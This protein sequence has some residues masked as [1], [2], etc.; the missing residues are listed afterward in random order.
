MAYDEVLRNRVRA[1]LVHT[2]RV[3][4]KGMFGWFA[5]LVMKSIRGH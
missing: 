1:A 3:G 2:R 5:I 4:K